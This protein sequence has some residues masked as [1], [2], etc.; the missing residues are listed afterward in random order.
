MSFIQT[1]RG[2]CHFDKYQVRLVSFNI[3]IYIYIYMISKTH[4]RS[5][6]GWSKVQPAYGINGKE[7]KRVGNVLG[8]VV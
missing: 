8:H 5:D 2:E 4:L 1:F 3:Y 6:M 7:N